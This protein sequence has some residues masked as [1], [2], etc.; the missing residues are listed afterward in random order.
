M[1]IV[2]PML[3]EPIE[4]KENQIN[5]LVVENAAALRE[6]LLCLSA[7]CAGEEGD[8]ILSE[9]I[10]LLELSKNAVFVRD[11]FALDFSSKRVTAKL[12]QEAIATGADYEAA[13]REIMK[14][15]NEIA[16]K[17]C[18]S[19]DYDAVFSEI[20]SWEQLVRLL[21]FRVDL[22]SLSFPERVLEF[23]KVQ[24]RFFGKTLFVFYNLKALLS[25]QELELFYRSLL[26]EKL[27]VFLIEDVQRRPLK[28]LE[29]TAIIDEDLCVF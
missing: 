8:F 10:Q 9:G 3:P 1:K 13:L 26:Y 7:Q 18:A 24:R 5:V 21:S 2:H 17:I 14:A 11:L 28:D 20:D 29:S 16:G 22:D 6:M 23:M 15:L 12:D 19:L 25:A 4:F 27:T